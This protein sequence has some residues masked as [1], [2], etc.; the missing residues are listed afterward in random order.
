P[1]AGRG[2]RGQALERAPVAV[3]HHRPRVACRIIARVH[4]E[5][6]RRAHA[7]RF[8]V[9]VNPAPVPGHRLAVEELWV[10]GGVARIVDQHDHR[11]ALHVDAAVVV[12]LPFRRIDP[13][14]REY[15]GRAPQGDQGPRVLRECDN[16]AAVRKALYAAACMDLELRALVED[17]RRD[18][19]HALQPVAMIA[20]A[21][22]HAPE[23]IDQVAQRQR[24]PP[25]AGLAAA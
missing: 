20:G 6:G 18:H 21:E 15:Y 5:T 17:G 9:L 14:A 24:L 1:R 11:L 25:G 23:L 4:D 16:I 13:V 3:P 19:W 12:P 22:V 10:A 8:L 2:A 7:R